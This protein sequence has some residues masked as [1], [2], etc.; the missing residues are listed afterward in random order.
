MNFSLSNEVS[1]P[2]SAVIIN[3]PWFECQGRVVD[4]PH[5]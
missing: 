3:N 4:I 2:E 5:C 1:N